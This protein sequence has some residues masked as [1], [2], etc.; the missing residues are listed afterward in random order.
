VRNASDFYAK[1]WNSTQPFSAEEG[2]PSVHREH[3]AHI[4]RI[5]PATRRDARF[6][7]RR[8]RAEL[9]KAGR[10]WLTSGADATK[11][12]GPKTHRTRWVSIAASRSPVF[13][14]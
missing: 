11:R 13:A 14:N 8:S 9:A 4:P 3:P 12:I 6:P 5:S 7:A 10:S 2:P 1:R